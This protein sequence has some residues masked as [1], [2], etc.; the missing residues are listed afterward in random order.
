MAN[1]IL[2]WLWTIDCYVLS[3]FL[4]LNGSNCCSYSITISLFYIGWLWGGGVSFSPDW[5][6]MCLRSF[7]HISTW[8]RSWDPG[9][10]RDAIIGK[11]FG[12][13]GRGV[14]CSFHIG[15]MWIVVVRG[16]SDVVSKTAT[17]NSS[18]PYIYA[19][20]H[21]QWW[22]LGWT[23]DLLC[24]I[25]CIG[26]Y[27]LGNSQAFQWLGLHAFTSRDSIPGWGTNTSQVAHHGQR[28]EEKE[29]RN[30]GL[31]FMSPYV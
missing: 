3:I 23:C 9:V 7:I 18:S 1:C 21:I 2:E 15:W 13:L 6:D 17:I 26:N 27:G 31:G 12:D 16:K 20:A 19:I 28:K 29:K 30:Y 10:A 11:D 4:F 25:Q 8:C 22:Y 24:K 14:W 5:E